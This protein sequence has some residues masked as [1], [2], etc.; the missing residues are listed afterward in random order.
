MKNDKLCS[1]GA[2]VWDNNGNEMDQ[3]QGCW[4]A[5][6]QAEYDDYDTEHDAIDEVH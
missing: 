6:E 5:Q 1:C 3:C 2:P 4:T